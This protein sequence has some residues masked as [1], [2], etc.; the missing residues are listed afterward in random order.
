MVSSVARCD[1]SLNQLTRLQTPAILH[2]DMTH[3]VVLKRVGRSGVAIHDP[4]LGPRV[5]SLKDASKHF[6]GIALELTPALHYRPPPEVP[7]LKLRSLLGPIAGMRSILL[8][9]LALSLILQLYTVAL[10]FYM[11]LVVDDGIGMND[12]DLILT[13]A[14]GFGL[15]LLIY[16]GA[17]QIRTRILAKVQ[18]ALAFQMGAGLFHHM[19]R[20]PLSYFEKRHVGDLVSRFG[21]LEPIRRLLA[22]GFITA[23]IDGFMA[24][25]TAAMIFVYAPMLG[26]VVVAGLMSYVGLRAIFFYKLRRASLDLM[27][28]HAGEG[29]AFMETARAIQSIK[30]F[31][32]EATRSAVWLNRYAEV[33]RAD[34][35][36][37]TLRQT[38]QSLN[39]FVFGIENIIVVYFGAQAVLGE[40]MTVGM[41]V[42]FMA[43]KQQFIS[44]A[45]SFVEKTVEFRMLD[46]HLD[47]LADIACSEPE[48]LSQRPDRRSGPIAGAIEVRNVSFRY[49]AGEPAVFANISFR[50]AAGDYVAITGPSGCGKT[51]LLKVMLGLINPSEGEVLVDD[52]PLSMIGNEAYRERIGVVMQDD[53]LLSGTIAENIC[54]FDESHD[55]EQMARCAR[56]AGIHDD[57]V[58]MPMGYNSLIGDMGTSLSG[59]QR[60]RILLARALYRRPR[61][62]F[63]DEGTSNLDVE[64]ERRV[65]EA[66]RGLGLTRV[67][68]AH[69][70]ETI[71][72]AS[73]RLVM[74][75]A[76][77]RECGRPELLD[78]LD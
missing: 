73:R 64:T 57:I 34:I 24:T 36:T 25:L 22:E 53:S 26:L 51:T 40:R 45:S 46:L 35:E 10:P 48:P 58:R 77:L 43:Y 62:L 11:Q 2:W 12:G 37:A 18:S 56:L 17:M 42:A 31:N 60:Q 49:A 68:I 21:S 32:G 61:I 70:P 20:L 72:T 55:I 50:I 71:A 30:L 27:V 69:R 8:Q 63:M 9:I 74:D 28:A 76:G 65:S 47:R 52:V 16:V 4:S 78:K 67:I 66:I 5:Y 6:T 7:R 15:A 3:Y 75:Q 38:F 39:Q 59:G 54:F 1:W 13:L 33:V 23:L 41:L 19:L 14:M 44:A 29:S